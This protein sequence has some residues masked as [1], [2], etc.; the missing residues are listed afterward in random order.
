[1]AAG[2]APSSSS[3]WSRAWVSSGVSSRWSRLSVRAVGP[4]SRISCSGSTGPGRGRGVL[5]GL[6]RVIRRRS[7][8]MAGAS[9]AGAAR[10]LVLGHFT[11]VSCSPSRAGAFATDTERIKQSG[12][13]WCRSVLAAPCPPILPGAVTPARPGPSRLHARPTLLSL[14]AAPVICE[15]DATAEE[16]GGIGKRYGYPASGSGLRRCARE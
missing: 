11:T 16:T 3:S 9:A 14:P 7:A 2:P 10:E 8:G 5:A 4:A 1:M 6:V 12:G 13:R 15:G